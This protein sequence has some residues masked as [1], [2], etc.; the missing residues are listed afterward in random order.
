MHQEPGLLA[1]FRH[2]SASS[3]RQELDAI[4]RSSSP[5]DSLQLAHEPNGPPD[6][7]FRVVFA[8]DASVG[9]TSFIRR[10]CDGVF[11]AQTVATLGTVT[12]T[13]QLR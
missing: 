4:S 1:P 6:R 8:G 11:L 2:S 7:T 12:P 5:L 10:A 3:I 13:L 9:K